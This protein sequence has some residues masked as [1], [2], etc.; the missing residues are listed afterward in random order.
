MLTVGELGL[1]SE[2]F[3]VEFGILNI[4]C[5][6]NTDVKRRSR[7]TS[8]GL[9]ER[10]KRSLL[11]RKSLDSEPLFVE[12]QRSFARGFPSTN[13][14]GR[15]RKAKREKRKERMSSREQQH[16]FLAVMAQLWR[17]H[18]PCLLSN[19]RAAARM[20]TNKL[21]RVTVSSQTMN[22]AREGTTNETKQLI[23]WDTHSFRKSLTLNGCSARYLER[24]RLDRCFAL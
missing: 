9:Y 3:G 13:D 1:L 15:Q 10:S 7:R 2:K 5:D 11:S 24:Q 19:R 16:H 23:V 6:E 12:T 14:K 20:G 8:T 18:C 21:A 22:T 4:V 17:W